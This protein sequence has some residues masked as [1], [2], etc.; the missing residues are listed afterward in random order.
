MQ[1]EHLE[2]EPVRKKVRILDDEVEEIYITEDIDEDI[3]SRLEKEIP[4]RRSII[5]QEEIDNKEEVQEKKESRPSL[6]EKT[7]ANLSNEEI[8]KQLVEELAERIAKTKIEFWQ[9]QEKLYD[10]DELLKN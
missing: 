3:K 4:K 1:E 6:S 10:L 7:E 5:Q 2:I 8:I 9:E